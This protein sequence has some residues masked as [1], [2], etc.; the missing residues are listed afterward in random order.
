MAKVKSKTVPNETAVPMQDKINI[1]LAVRDEPAKKKPASASDMLAALSGKAKPVAKKDTKKERPVMELSPEGQDLYRRFAPAKQLLDVVTAEVEA[2][3]GQLNLEMNESWTA[4]LWNN[5]SLPSNPEIRIF[6]ENNRLDCQGMYVVQERFKLQIPDNA[7]PTGS[8]VNLLVELGVDQTKAESLIDNEVDFTPQTSLRPFNE[9]VNGHYE[10]RQFIES[11]ATEKAVGQKLLE[12]V[13][14]ELDADEQALVLQNTPKSVVKKGFLQ[15]VTGYANNKDQ[16]AS[17][18]KVFVPVV[19][20]K[21]AKFAVSDSPVDKTQRLV[22]YAAQLLGS[23]DE[24][25]DDDSDD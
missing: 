18:L 24:D 8:I 20:N 16:L 12:F 7:D 21:G 14:N 11:S 1:P 6:D 3:K 22:D 10:D 5:K 13:M 19:Q 25:D 2:V 4:T 23:A 9:L 15:R 17:I